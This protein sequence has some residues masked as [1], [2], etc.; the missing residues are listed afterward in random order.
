MVERIPLDNDKAQDGRTLFIETTPTF[1]DQTLEIRIQWSFILERW[2]MDVRHVERDKRVI[3]NMVS[4]YYPYRYRPYVIMMF[5]DRS[6]QSDVVTRNNL[7]DEVGLYLIRDIETG[8][9]DT[10]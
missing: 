1:F 4:P 7:G 9:I 8:L 6:R 2:K 3:S 5:I 10:E